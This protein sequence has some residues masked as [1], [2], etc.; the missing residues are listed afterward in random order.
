[1]RPQKPRKMTHFFLSE[2]LAFRRV[3]GLESCSRTSGES[4][5]HWQSV[6]D[7]RVPPYQLH[8]ENDFSKQICSYIESKIC[9]TAFIWA[10][11][12]DFLSWQ[13]RWTFWITE[14]MA[15][16]FFSVQRLHGFRQVAQHVQLHVANYVARVN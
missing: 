12:K 9:F 13:H 1:M 7:T 15:C 16:D 14:E 3:Y 8:H 2:P 4:N 10:V 5:H 11:E 6:S